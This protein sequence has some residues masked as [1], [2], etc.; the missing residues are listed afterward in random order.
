M[1]EG[2]GNEL[3]DDLYY[4]RSTRATRSFATN[5]RALARRKLRYL[6]AAA[7]LVPPS[8][9]TEDSLRGQEDATSGTA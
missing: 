8:T 5:L 9:I 2:F 6:H 3:A 7:D 4:D 1:I